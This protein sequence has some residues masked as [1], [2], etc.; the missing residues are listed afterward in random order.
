[1]FVSFATTYTDNDFVRLRKYLIGFT[2]S[3]SGLDVNGDGEIT[4]VDLVRMKKLMG[5]QG[6]NELPFIPKEH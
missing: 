3:D 5:T 4:I 6:D 2:D 1:M